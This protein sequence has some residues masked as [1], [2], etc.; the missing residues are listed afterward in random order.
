MTSLELPAEV[1]SV[2]TARRFVRDALAAL[3]DED[4][5]EAAALCVTEL[6]T[7]AVLHARTEFRVGVTV[8]PEAVRVEV[9]DRSPMEPRRLVHTVG[10]STGRGMDMVALLARAW[11][12]VRDDAAT[13]TVWCELPRV[14]VRS[15]TGAQV[16]PVEGPDGLDELLERWVDLPGAPPSGRTTSQDEPEQPTGEHSLVVV[17]Q[18]Y[19]VRLGMRAREHTSAILRECALLSHSAPSTSAPARLVFLAQRI[20]ANYAGELASVE[21]QRTQALERGDRTVDLRY[22]VG[23]GTREV[24]ENWQAVVRELDRYAAGSSLLTRA[25]PADQVRLRDWTLGEFIAQ[26]DGAP[27]RPWTGPTD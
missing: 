16:A 1:E 20:T 4:L 5:V 25:T 8:R 14:P 24:V 3:A 26:L 12:V 17:L 6:A 22:T 27:P 13:K 19:P 23:R 9:E 2:P 11:G 21:Q 15:R 18:G 10:S 7:N